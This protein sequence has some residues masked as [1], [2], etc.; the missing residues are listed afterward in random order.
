MIAEN[1]LPSQREVM[2]NSAGREESAYPD[3]GVHQLNNDRIVMDKNRDLP[4][5]TQ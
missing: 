2:L 1:R 4:D 5:K 3:N